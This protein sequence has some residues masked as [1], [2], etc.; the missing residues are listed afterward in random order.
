MSKFASILRVWFGAAPT[1]LTVVLM[2]ALGWGLP[3]PAW[4]EDPAPSAV[5]P[6]PAQA[7]GGVVRITPES[8]LALVPG[9]R[10]LVRVA[11]PKSDI[12]VLVPVL[13]PGQNQSGHQL[14]RR[15]YA[16]GK[17]AGN[18]GDLYENRDHGHSRLPPE[19][20]PQ[21]THIAYSDGVQAQKLDYGAALRM[22]FDAPLIGNS[23][24][25]LTAGPMWRSQPR[26]MLTMPDETGHKTGPQRLYQNYGAGQIHVYPEHHDHDPE[27]G[28]V[29][30]A[31]TPYY[32]ISKGSS[33]SD[34]A[35][36]QALAM[37]LAAFRPDTKAFLR[38]TGLIA[39]TVQMVYRRA[40]VGVRSRAAYLSGAAHPSVFDGRDIDLLR[41]VGLANAIA[42]DNVPAV[43]RL[44]MLRD[45][46]AREGVD[47]FGQG[48]S[49]VLFDTPSA[50]AR[51]WRSR[52]GQRRMIVSAAA[53]RDPNGRKLQF[54]WVLL[55]GDP[56]RVTITPLDPSGSRARIDL[57]WQD[58]RA[59]PGTPDIMSSRIDIGVFA[60]NGVYDSA[61]AFLSVL[62]PHHET[63]RY[64]QGQ[65]G[66][67]RV[68]SID[69]GPEA[70]PYADPLIFPEMPWRDEYHY[71]T[72]GQ[73]TG[74]TR[75]R[76][77][78]V[79]AYDAAG[80]IIL[81]RDAQGTPV[82]TAIV[83]YLPEQER[84]GLVRLHEALFPVK[85]GQ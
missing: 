54:S 50:I 79:D 6:P 49:E 10:G 81:A 26:M 12:P 11:F 76:L 66:E 40:R 2:F 58:P 82:E 30:P 48:L 21:L 56:A 13:G 9:N 24:T 73:F 20:H 22:I 51:V 14:L 18:E 67:L 16:A 1:A 45:L 25:A 52:A 71:D 84:S 34:Q 74:W 35:H 32:L 47:Y 4:A 36:L 42:P 85:A 78:R 19:A 64:E 62:L 83:Q 69:R 46:K 37:I 61:P 39:A 5:L 57:I 65:D 72:T 23:S 43:V 3:G 33:G 41:M 70:G 8:I 55:R 31:N 38:K 17:A 53:T 15:L 80:R 27:H 28:D 59:A 75:H 7:S 77:G 60:N 44:H 29:L 68:I 63:R